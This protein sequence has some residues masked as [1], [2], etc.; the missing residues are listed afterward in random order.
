MLDRWSLRFRVFLFFLL[1]AV[2]G[3]G[4]IIGGQVFIHYRGAGI[5]EM[6]QAAAI[7]VFV[8]AL[9]TFWVWQLF[10]ENMV[11]PILRLAR[12]ARAAAHA[13]SASVDLTAAKYL[14]ALGGA[15]EDVIGALAEARGETETAIAEA[16]VEAKR[17]QQQLETILRDLNQGV[18]ICTLDHRILLYNRRA[19]EIL[20]LSGDIG[21]GR[22]LFHLVTAQPFRHALDRL[23]NRFADG[24]HMTHKDGMG[25]LVVC[26]TA[27][28]GRTLQG[29]VS[30]MLDPEEIE[31]S[32]YVVAF[33]DVT[34]ELADRVKRDRLLRDASD[35]LR[36]PVANLRAAV[37]MLTDPTT[38]A[39]SRA[40]FEAVLDKE[41]AS[42]AARLDAFDT[43]RRA[44]TASAWPMSDMF[45]TTVFTAVIRRRTG[46]QN[47]TAEIVGQPVWVN[48]DSLTIVELLDVLMNKIAEAAPTRTFTMTAEQSGGRVYLDIAWPGAPLSMTLLDGW[49]AEPLDPA[50]GG[51]TGREG[52][53]RHETDFWCEP[54]GEGRA[55]LRL[56]LA[57]PVEAHRGRPP[58]VEARPEFYDF[59]LM[60]RMVRSDA[61]DTPLRDLDY[62]VFDTETTGLNPSQG[63]LMISIA[64]VRIVNGRVLRG[65]VFDQLINPRRN[66]PAA[67]TKIHHI[68]NEMVAEAPFI[69]DVLPRF[70]SF[71]ENSVLVAHNAAFDMRFLTLQQDKCRVRFEHPVLDTVLLAAHL[72][73]QADSLTLDTLAERFAIEIPPEARHTALG[74]SLATAELMLRLIDMLEAAGVRTLGEAAAASRTAGAIRRKQA[75]Y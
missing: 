48:C 15:A 40:D 38:D 13:G 64:G 68:T 46:P 21:L 43:D 17:R 47:F 54:A 33:E 20:R 66:I 45:S 53:E 69:E 57:G 56:P 36:R 4:A 25:C 51:V 7:G 58:V 23:T 1:I 6:V 27:D 67:S 50:V 14:G 30:L 73:G 10:D 74:D 16:T 75:A 71:C 18:L 41:T 55:R 28:G 63:D 62:V 5:N 52:L 61:D 65:E 35:A 60:A 34:V 72:D 19:L 32:G 22:P 49:L 37:E 2:V 24:R 39:E 26:A 31:P 70:H 8:F 44:V 9:L 59:D 29:R 11:R 12:D 3:C 42:L